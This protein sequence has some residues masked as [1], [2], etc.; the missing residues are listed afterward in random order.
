MVFRVVDAHI[1]LEP[2]GKLKPA[3]AE[4]LE[5]DRP[6]LAHILRYVSD[7]G[8]LINHLDEQEISRVAVINY[9]SPEVMGFGNE[10]NEIGARYRDQYPDRIIAFGGVDPHAK[11]DP[12]HQI[13]HLLDHL[14][15][16]G[17]KLHPPHQLVAANSYLDG[18]SV[19]SEVYSL[20]QERAVPV[21]IHTGTSIF[22]GSRIKFGDP[23]HCDDVA[24]D[25]PE[26]PL[27]LAHGGRPLWMET[28]FFLARRH[29]NVYLDLSGI[30]PQKLL[31]Y[32]PRLESIA[33][34]CLFGTDWPSPGVRSIRE[35]VDTFLKQPLSDQ[36]KQQILA[37]AADKLFPPR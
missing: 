26:L 5:R 31:D 13:R 1:H 33:H 8:L 25:Y 11:G 21:M 32:F 37:G 9:P 12:A 22:P 36:A 15:M 23:I 27:I 29:A 14:R 6:D 3:V 20:C 24:V 28:A 17:V 18:N 10:G 4:V 19:L 2:W 16:D 7:P 34:K 30:P 35:N